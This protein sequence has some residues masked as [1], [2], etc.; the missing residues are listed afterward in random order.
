MNTLPVTV[1]R[2]IE[3]LGLFLVGYLIIVGNDII[4]P[5]LMAFFISIVC[6]AR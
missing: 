1:K 6:A 5:L 4:A 3:L 2:S